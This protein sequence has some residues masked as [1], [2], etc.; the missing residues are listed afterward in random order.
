M[1]NI[2]LTL[3]I[4]VLL[5]C[6]RA[7]TDNEMPET[8][9]WK[10][11]EF[12]P[13]STILLTFDSLRNFRILQLTDLHYDQSNYALNIRQNITELVKRSNP[14]LII[15]TGDIVSGQPAT[16]QWLSMGLFLSQIKIPFLIA[17]G[18]H[19][20][21]YFL[22]RRDLYEMIRRFPYCINRQYEDPEAFLPG[23]MAVQVMQYQSEIPETILYLF[24]SNDYNNPEKQVGIRADQTEWFRSKSIPYDSENNPNISNGLVFMHV[25]LPQ[26]RE[27]TNQPQKDWVGNRGENE[28]IGLGGD[29]FFEALKKTGNIYGIFCGHD[30]YNDYLIN[31]QGIALCYGRK[32]GSHNT[33]Q[34][35]PSG[36]RVIELH[37]GEKGFYTYLLD[38]EGNKTSAY[39]V[40]P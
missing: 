12:P 36:G 31:Y 34:R 11:W 15:L 14:D 1:K 13:D 19:D 3:S 8:A 29:G 24:D 32:S 20:S 9:H 5:L 38:C 4:L 40:V 37:S 27:A 23:D 7:C 16:Y 25:P 33:Y 39:L 30:H 22:S 18:N 21:Q 26:Y 10:T 28:C 35:Y 17:L 2:L 6:S